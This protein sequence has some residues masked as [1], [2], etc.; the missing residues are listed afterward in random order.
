MNSEQERE[1]STPEAERLGID[2]IRP[3]MTE[4]E[5]RRALDEILR[6]LRGEE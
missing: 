5:K 2:E 4:A 3:Q 6:V 1:Q